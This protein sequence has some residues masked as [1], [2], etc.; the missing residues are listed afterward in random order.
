MT[1]FFE[2]TTTS[3]YMQPPRGEQ[4]KEKRGSKIVIIATNTPLLSEIS[5]FIQQDDLK[6]MIGLHNNGLIILKKQDR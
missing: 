3:P 6:Q 5:L 4:E 1:I 2:S